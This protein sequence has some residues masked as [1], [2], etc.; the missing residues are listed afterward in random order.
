[1]GTRN[2]ER[3]EW[4]AADGKRTY[5]ADLVWEGSAVITPH[6]HDFYEMFMVLQGKFDE[7]SDGQH[8]MLK[9]RRLHVMSTE[10]CH[11]F[12]GKDGE[13]T[14]VLRNIAVE[15]EWF[16]EILSALSV[17][18]DQICGHY[19]VDE[20]FFASFVQK[21]NM[22]YES[23]P[24]GKAYTF[25]MRN[26]IEDV[27]IAAALQRGNENGIP[28]WL[29]HAYQEME[30][31]ENTAAG[32]PRL[33]ELTEKSQE[34]LTR[35]FRRHYHMSPTEYINILRLRNAARLLRATNEPI[36]NIVF[37]CGFN[38]ISYFNRLFKAHYN[39]TPRDYRN[40]NKWRSCQNSASM[41]IKD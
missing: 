28:K 12:C 40:E 36:I 35:E 33:L 29:R 2:Y 10:N 38:S 15:K 41:P 18:P 8:V 13:E 24:D 21:T 30:K 27:I 11:G 19:I 1:M 25:L 22:I 3:F 39:M 4:Y 26:I 5:M 20:A 34:H 9:R 7:V 6:T 14:A 23:Y 17:E 16:E 32:L 37:D 31:E